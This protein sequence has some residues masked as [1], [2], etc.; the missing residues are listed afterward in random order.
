MGPLKVQT[1]IKAG[2]ISPSKCEDNG[3][4]MECPTSSGPYPMPEFENCYCSGGGK[5]KRKI[6]L[7]KFK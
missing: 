6:C 2:C 5:D 7:W 4:K 3:G 1:G